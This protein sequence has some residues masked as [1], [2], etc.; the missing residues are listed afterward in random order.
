MR[1]PVGAPSPDVETCHAW[2]SRPLARPSLA[3]RS[4]LR[5][6]AVSSPEQ[7]GGGVT[8]H[9]RPRPGVFLPGGWREAA[10]WQHKT[11]NATTQPSLLL[12][13][14]QPTALFRPFFPG[15]TPHPARVLQ[16]SPFGS[17]CTCRSRSAGAFGSS[18]SFH[19]DPRKEEAQGASTS[20]TPEA[21]GPSAAGSQSAPLPLQGREEPE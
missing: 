2:V 13:E 18:N 5:L 17:T 7:D 6:H 19:K 8:D 12:T 10:V 3:P 1:K 11:N 20:S 9:L 16:K 14:V 15:S 21:V 4:P